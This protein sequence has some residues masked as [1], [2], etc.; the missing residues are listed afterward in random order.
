MQ[1]DCI[2]RCHKKISVP[3]E[4]V[5]FQIWDNPSKIKPPLNKYFTSNCIHLIHKACQI[6]SIYLYQLG[7]L[8]PSSHS[9]P[10]SSSH[11]FLI[12]PS[13]SLPFL[14]ISVSSTALDVQH[15]LKPFAVTSGEKHCLYDPH[16]LNNTFL[17]F[18]EPMKIHKFLHRWC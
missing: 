14:N 17:N 8:S 15:F 13:S 16:W 1:D 11:S 5:F 6:L 4:N 18:L 10:S 12:F 9:F 7:S 3:R 2:L